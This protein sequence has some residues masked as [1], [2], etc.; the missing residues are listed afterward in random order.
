MIE[1]RAT[2]L[3]LR[4]GRSE[5]AEPCGSICYEAFKTIAD[6][7]NFPPTFPHRRLRVDY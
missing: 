5:D 1:T 2:H 7:H 4:P 6:E 3:T